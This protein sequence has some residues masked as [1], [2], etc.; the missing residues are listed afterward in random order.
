[1]VVAT[2]PVVLALT[3]KSNRN[4]TKIPGRCTRRIRELRN[5]KLKRAKNKT[6]KPAMEEQRDTR[7]SMGGKRDERE[8]GERKSMGRTIEGGR[9]NTTQNG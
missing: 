5:Y 1:M 7:E 9:V 6:E 3:G 4:K 8:R 2:V